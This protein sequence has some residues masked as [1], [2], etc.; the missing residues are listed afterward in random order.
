MSHSFP[1]AA[2][3]LK[4]GDFSY[5]RNS[6]KK[7]VTKSLIVFYKNSKTEDSFS[8]LGISVS[9]KAG[10]AVK[11]N[12]FKRL[13]REQ[14]RQSEVKLGGLDLMAVVKNK[15]DLNDSIVVEDFKYITKRL[16]RSE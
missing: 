13:L 14:F 8:R 12:R 11:R 2:R 15:K 5:L 9:K 6:P 16:I 3:L 1:K 10:N 4:P 7:I